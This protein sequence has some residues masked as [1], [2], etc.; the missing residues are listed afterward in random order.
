MPEEN[1]TQCDVENKQLKK[2]DE[3]ENE[4]ENED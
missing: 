2:E 3:N 1:F 4:N